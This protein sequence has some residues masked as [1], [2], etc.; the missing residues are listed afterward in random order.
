[1]IEQVIQ[2]EEQPLDDH[3]ERP[4]HQGRGDQRIAQ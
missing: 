4:D 2:L 1:M 3:A